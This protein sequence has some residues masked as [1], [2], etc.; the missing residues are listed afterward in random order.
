M[1]KRKEATPPIMDVHSDFRKSQ[2]RI[3]EDAIRIWEKLQL[4]LKYWQRQLRLDDVDIEMRWLQWD[5][6]PESA[7]RFEDNSS[8]HM[9]VIAFRPPHQ[10]YSMPNIAS[11]NCDY[12]VILVHELLH[13]RNSRWYCNDAVLEI[14]EDGLGNRMLEESIDCIAEALVRARRGI[15]R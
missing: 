5:E 1:V 14:L 8:V 6:F 2:S 7:A 15:T 11:F 10:L 12:E 13:A 4:D 3:A 9:F